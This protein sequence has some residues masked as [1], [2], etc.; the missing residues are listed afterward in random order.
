M[1]DRTMLLS[2]FLVTALMLLMHGSR[3]VDNGNNG[4]ACAEMEV[5]VTT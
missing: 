5:L 1:L 3:L 4:F 2:C